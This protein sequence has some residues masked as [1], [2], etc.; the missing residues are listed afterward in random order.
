MPADFQ[1][2]A[3]NV[4]QLHSRLTELSAEAVHVGVAP[5]QDSDWFELLEHKLLPQLSRPAL[6]VVAVVGGTNIG[7]SVLF[8]HLD[9]RK[10]QRRQPLGRRD[11]TPGV[12]RSRKD[13]TPGDL[14]QRD[15]ADRF[16]LAILLR[17]NPP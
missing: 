16:L 9:G 14:V 10:C 12:P 15:L 11:Q 4:Q 8:N 3:A 7:K 5:P 1:H 6:L 2:W 13:L 17:I